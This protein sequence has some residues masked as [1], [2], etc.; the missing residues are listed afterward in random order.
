VE[1]DAEGYALAWGLVHYL[2]NKKTDAFRAYM[3][4]LSKYQ[5]LDTATEPVAGKVDPL[6][7]KYFGRDFEALERELQAY[8]TSKNMKAEYI[9]P[10][11]N[12]THY[13]VKSVEKVGTAFAVKAVVTT[14]PAA[15]KKWKEEEEAAHKK[16]SF[17]TIVCKSRADAERQVQFLK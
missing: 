1:I 6:F 11:E 14:S 13:I 12:Q 8:L 9:D 10:I 15:A 16:A 5:P 3:A 17:F 4:D 7:A 2:A